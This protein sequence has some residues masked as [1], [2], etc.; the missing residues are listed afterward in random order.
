MAG[1]RSSFNACLCNEDKLEK[2]LSGVS[3]T[4]FIV[5]V[6]PGLLLPSLPGDIRSI[7]MAAYNC[8]KWL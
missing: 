8:E 1:E 5:S 6:K 3:V 4:R 2:L 7:F